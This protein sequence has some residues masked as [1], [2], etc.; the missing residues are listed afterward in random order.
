MAVLFKR[1]N[2]AGKVGG[3]MVHRNNVSAQVVRARCICLCAANHR[4]WLRVWAGGRT[5][6]MAAPQVSSSLKSLICT[7][8]HL[9]IC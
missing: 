9:R 7:L 8:D 5:H 6:L 2:L 4:R 3:L 1:R